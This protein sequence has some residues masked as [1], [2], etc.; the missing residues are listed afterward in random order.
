MCGNDE[1]AKFLTQTLRG[2]GIR[3]PEDVAV[4]GFDMTRRACWIPSS[5]R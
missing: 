1:I 3:V 5:P 4:T 2:R